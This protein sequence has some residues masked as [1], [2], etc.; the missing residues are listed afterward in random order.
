[1]D[2]GVGVGIVYE[3]DLTVGG[4]S[5]SVTNGLLA[6]NG[7]SLLLADDGASVLLQG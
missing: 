2:I 1:M 6:D 7:A 5:S 3:D 4:S